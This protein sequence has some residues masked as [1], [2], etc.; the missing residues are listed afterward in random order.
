MSYYSLA[1]KILSYREVVG[2]WTVEIWREC[3]LYFGYPSSVGDA[4][5]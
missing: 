1:K 3:S 4:L 2:A 5:T